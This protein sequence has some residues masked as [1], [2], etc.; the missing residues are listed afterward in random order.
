MKLG[1]RQQTGKER[2]ASSQQRDYL[3]MFYLTGKIYQ[4]NDGQSKDQLQI[5]KR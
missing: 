2:G 4:A 1:V 5:K 3:E